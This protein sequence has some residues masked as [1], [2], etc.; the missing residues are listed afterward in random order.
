RG[1]MGWPGSRGE[2][3]EDV[4][5]DVT[6][7]V[8]PAPASRTWRPV[9]AVLLLVAIAAAAVVPFARSAGKGPA[10]ALRAA[11]TSSAERKTVDVTLVETLRVGGTTLHLAGSGGLDLATHEATLRARVGGT[12]VGH[13]LDV[14]LRMVDDTLYEQIPGISTLVAGKT[15]VSIPAGTATSGTAAGSPSALLGPAGGPGT[16]LTS[17]ADTTGTVR[18]LGTRRV[19]GGAATGYEITMDRSQWIAGVSSQA[20]SA[21]ERQAISSLAVHRMVQKAFVS[22][23]GLLQLLSVAFSFTEAGMRV[24]S[25]ESI[26]FWT[27]GTVLHV[28]AP[29]PRQ[30][31]TLPRFERAEAKHGS[32][33]TE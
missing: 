14:Q 18:L 32:I 24:G 31:V 4:A 9:F 19:E 6:G 16:L 26:Y 33:T 13:S 15:W 29:P 21:R 8:Q 23:D 30:V 12:K 27:F 20:L 5:A 1:R 28:T 11:A 3:S 25:R 17:L 2:A 22:R 10:A 7:A